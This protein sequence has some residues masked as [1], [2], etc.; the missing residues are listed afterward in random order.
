MR[1]DNLDCHPSSP[2]SS[3]PPSLFPPPPPPPPPSPLS[4]RERE[5]DRSRRERTSWTP[6]QKWIYLQRW[7]RILEKAF[8]SPLLTPF[9]RLSFE[10]SVIDEGRTLAHFRPSAS[11]LHWD[12]EEE[13]RSVF[14]TATPPDKGEGGEDEGGGGGGGRR[15]RRRSEDEEGGSGEDEDEDEQ[16]REEEGITAGTITIYSP[17]ILARDSHNLEEK[18]IEYVGRMAHEMLHAFFV[19]YACNC[20]RFCRAVNASQTQIGVLGHGECW[21]DAMV[22]IQGALRRDLGALWE[23]T[24]PRKPRFSELSPTGRTVRRYLEEEETWERKR[25]IARLWGSVNCN[26]WGLLCL[27]CERGEVRL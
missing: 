14:P 7:S 2:L 10:T 22:A 4:P 21:C 3:S 16:G 17:F 23:E 6:T 15:R 5:R 20:P 24:G 8:F 1:S 11:F 9:I 27:W 13:T 12:G 26:L 18:M 25:R 19:M